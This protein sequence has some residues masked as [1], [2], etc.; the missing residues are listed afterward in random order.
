MNPAP[1]S[2]LRLRAWI[3]GAG[4]ALCILALAALWRFS[5]LARQA[6]QETVAALIRSLRQF[7][8]AP[9]ALVPAYIVAD[10]LLFPNMILNAAVVVTIGGVRGWLSA[11]IASLCSASLFFFIGCRFG[12]LSA[13]AVHGK[14]LQTVRRALRRGGL[15]AVIAVRLTPIAPYTVV[16]T[17][18]GAIRL[19]YRHF[20]AGT[21][22]AHIPGLTL[23]ALVGEQAAS[24]AARPSVRRIAGLAA[25]LAVAAL[26]AWALRRRARAHVAHKAAPRS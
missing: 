5:P 18:A 16:N 11:M 12:A 13:R 23:M 1:R 15:G 19:K 7:W 6:N 4:A 2:H 14:R 8:W 20:L 9:L 3:I 25:L 10:G 17:L 22:I 21:C 26:A 24:V